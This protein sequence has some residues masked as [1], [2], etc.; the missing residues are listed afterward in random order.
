MRR[1]VLGR[2]RGH[3]TANRDPR[4]APLRPQGL[5]QLHSTFPIS[6]E[7]RDANQANATVGEGIA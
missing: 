7:Q 4:A 1:H 6:F 5:D 3:H 2:Q